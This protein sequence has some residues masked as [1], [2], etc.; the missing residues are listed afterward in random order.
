M[1]TR[2]LLAYLTIVAIALAACAG[3]PDASQGAATPNQVATSAAPTAVATRAIPARAVITADGV[4]E[5]LTAP[6][7]FGAEVAAKV[8][9]V[10]VEPGQSVRAG[11]VLATLDDTALRDALADAR[12]QLGLIEAQIAQSQRPPTQA[13]LASARAALAAAQAQYQAVKR[14][15]AVGE[16]AQTR[17]SWEAAWQSYLAAQV[18]RDV[19]C[20]PPLGPESTYCKAQEAGYGN[21]YESER[22]ALER[23]QAV[24]QPVS[25]ERLA[26]AWASVVAADA[27]LKALEAGASEEARQVAAAQLNQA[28]SAVR[29]AEDNLRQ[30]VV[31]APCACIV[32]EVNVAVG[33]APKGVAFVLVDLAG[34]RFKTTNLTERELGAVRVGDAAEVRLRAHDQAITGTV[35]A[36]L[37]QAQGAQDGAA[38]F[39]VLID[40]APSD[41]VLL[42]GMTG[43]VE[44]AAP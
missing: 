8:T 5:T 24:Q 31:L 28:R 32:Q 20:G 26:Q 19:A 9:A 21:A 34:M 38:L 23:L 33:S 44:I 2:P 37:P 16:I 11:A 17:L 40:L 14:G 35:A 29:R 18:N 1:H 12:L 6:L 39:T 27:R 4:L 25:R 36:I 41:L 15:P 13:D 30:A 43:R 3:A 22:A 7:P 10:N 42:P